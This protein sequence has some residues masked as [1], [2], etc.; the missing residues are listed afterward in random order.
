M[1]L[2]LNIQYVINFDLMQFK[3]ILTSL[4]FQILSINLHFLTPGAKFFNLV[5]LI[6]YY[7]NFFKPLL[8]ILEK[9]SFK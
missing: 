3:Y 8:T 4:N 1:H 2:L 5:V 6:S 9:I 7:L